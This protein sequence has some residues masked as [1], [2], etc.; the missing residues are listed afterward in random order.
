MYTKLLKGKK[1]DVNYYLLAPALAYDN[2]GTCYM[3]KVMY[4]NIL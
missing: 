1:F 2:S 4:C 3:C